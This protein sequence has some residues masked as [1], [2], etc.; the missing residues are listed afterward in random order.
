MYYPDDFPEDIKTPDERVRFSLE[1]G[2]GKSLV[3]EF[4]RG[5]MIDPSF[6]LKEAL[7]KEWFTDREAVV[8]AM[9][10]RGGRV[11]HDF[12]CQCVMWGRSEK[13]IRILLGTGLSANLTDSSGTPVLHLAA[14]Q[15]RAKLVKLLLELGADINARGSRGETPLHVARAHK[16]EKIEKLLL[17]KG[18]DPNIPTPATFQKSSSPA[19]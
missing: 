16:R 4:Q 15:G 8:K 6:V 10:E 1:W 11:D 18:A 3:E 12:F 7:S 17:Q 2:W 5:S 14:W 13:M 19:I 9:A